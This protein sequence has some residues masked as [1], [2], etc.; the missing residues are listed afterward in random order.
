M[1]LFLNWI[2]NFTWNQALDLAIILFL[3]YELFRLVR[4]TSALNILLSIIGVYVCWQIALALEM[5]VVSGLL[6]R[7]ISMGLLGIVVIF[8]PEL[9][10]FLFMLSTGAIRK[11]REQKLLKRVFMKTWGK[12]PLHITQIIQACIHMSLSRTGA[13][14]ILTQQNKLPA[15][16]STGERMDAMISSSLIE[17]IFFKNSPLHDGAMIIE[18]NKIIAARCILP[19]SANLGLRHRSAIGVTEQSDALAIIVSE[20]TGSV[21]YCQFGEITYDVSP[22][23]LRAEIEKFFAEAEEEMQTHHQKH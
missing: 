10:R 1:N 20:E 13:L 15:V 5:P 12:R 16:I 7:V 19:V 3:A 8:Q 18:N 21:S 14:I 17:N 4:G 9:R 2:E 11:Q 22:S 6:D 23:Q